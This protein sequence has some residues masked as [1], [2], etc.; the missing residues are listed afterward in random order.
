M[1]L[2]VAD[3]FPVQY[4]AQVHECHVWPATEVD[5]VGGLHSAWCPVSA[6]SFVILPRSMSMYATGERA[7]GLATQTTSARKF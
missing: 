3:I 6:L 7:H 2:L 5:V 1:T 4:R